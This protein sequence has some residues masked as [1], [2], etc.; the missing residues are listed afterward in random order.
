MFFNFTNFFAIFF[1]WNFLA[2]VWQKRISGRKIFSLFLGLS[3][4]DLDRN[5]A[6]MMFL[7]FFAIFFEI[8]QPGSGWNGIR[9]ENFFSLFLSLS[10]SGLD[11]NIAGMMFFFNFFEFFCYFFGILQPGLGRKGIQDENFFLSF[12]AY[13]NP[14]R[15][16]IMSE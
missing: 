16:E 10:Q 14:V 8:F 12:S 1:F 9:N 7:N 2:R 6:E 11:R 13:L 3:Q 5:I 4:P 15:I